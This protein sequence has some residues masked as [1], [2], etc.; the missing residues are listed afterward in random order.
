MYELLTVTES[1][2]YADLLGDKPNLTQSMA[3]TM[4]DQSPYHGWLNHPKLGSKA[5]E[6]TLA[7]EK[8]TLIHGLLHGDGE[9]DTPEGV[10][11]LDFDNYRPKL[12]REARDQ[13]TEA[14]LTPMLRHEWERCKAAATAA[15]KFILDNIA[16][17]NVPAPGD[18]QVEGTILWNETATDGTIVPCKAR[19][20]LWCPRYLTI[21]DYKT[22]GDA[23]PRRLPRQM[24]EKGMDIQAA[25]YSRA[26]AS[27]F[28]DLAGRTQFI[29]VFIESKEP[30]MCVPVKPDGMMMKLGDLK[31]QRAV[32]LFAEC[33]RTGKWPGYADRV[34]SMSPSPWALQDEIAINQAA[35]DA[36][37]DAA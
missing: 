24:T 34:L 31:W 37:G 32:D 8:G 4:I 14:G 26:I 7:M 3:H 5:K 18:G 10:V 12:A 33:S 35:A 9:M 29:N 20:D 15:R 27:K 25:C 23:N 11:I 19:L 17:V 36:F 22:T 1:I 30:H 28:P 13:T 16:K 6:P 21:V 2:Y